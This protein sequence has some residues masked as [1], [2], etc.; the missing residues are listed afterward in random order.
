MEEYEVVIVGA[1]PAGLAAALTLG[2]AQRRVLVCNGGRPRNWRSR[3]ISGYLTR[4]G[5]SPGKFLRLAEHELDLYRTV[6]LIE[7]KVVRAERR[8]TDFMLTAQDGA[9]FATRKLLLT[10]GLE[11]EL[12]PLPGLAEMFA[13]SVFTCP[14]CDGWEN[15]DQPIAVYAPDGDGEDMALTL[16]CWSQDIVILTDGE[17]VEF[18][19]REKVRGLGISYR[20]EK[21]SRLEGDRRGQLQRIHFAQGTHLERTCLFLCTPQRA[22]GGTLATQLEAKFEE[23]NCRATNVPGLFAAGDITGQTQMVAVAAGQGVTAAVE[24]NSELVKEE[25]RQQQA[26]LT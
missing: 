11:E 23:E 26:A 14:Y 18:D 9:E 10:T 19:R 5:V 6:R 12:P 17:H 1:G 4:D 16:R 20:S 22:R 15:R 13:R 25:V 3:K 2:R 7:Q 8:A 21:V 24:I